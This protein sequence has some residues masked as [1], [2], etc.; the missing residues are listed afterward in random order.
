MKILC[1]GQSAYD[2]TLPVSGYPIENRKYKI[3]D[4]YECGGGSCN[5]A[6]YLLA[7]WG[8]D[9]YL[10][11]SIGK[12]IYGKRIKDE[13]LNVGVNIDYFE[14][15][16]NV[17]T[18]TSYIINNIEN[19]SRTIITNKNPLMHFKEMFHIDIK[20]D[21]ILLDGNDYEMA[22]KVLKDNPNAIKIIDAGSMKNG[23][24]EL[25]KL[26]DYI[27]CSN[28]FARDYTKINFSYD[29]TKTLKE[30]YD[31]IDKDFDGKL[32]ITLESFGSMVKIDDNYYTVPSIKVDSVDSTGAGDI[33]HGAFTY[34]IANN[35]SLLETLHYSNIAGALSVTKIGSK[36]SMPK[37]EEVINY[38]G[39]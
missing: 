33:Y 38:H 36:A 32:V 14:E 37:K 34:F 15:I 28:D 30:V 12:D 8:M 35:Y 24:I 17:N 10:A 6:A 25:C 31:L 26:C 11:S 5:N 21:V 16:D 2:I 20:P 13:L 23:T 19:S 3:K 9:V 27:V 29:D 7:M 18:T 4:V 1:V 39:I 22:L